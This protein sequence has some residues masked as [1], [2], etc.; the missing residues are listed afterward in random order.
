MI[1]DP[2]Y[3]HWR[4]HIKYVGNVQHSHFMQCLL[5]IDGSRQGPLSPHALWL[6]VLPN[7]ISLFISSQENA[8]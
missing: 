2:K 8:I 3:W 7:P 1:V 5:R 6:D 4:L